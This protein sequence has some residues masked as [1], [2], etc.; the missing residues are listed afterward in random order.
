MYL[1]LQVEVK[2]GILIIGWY[3]RY[4]WDVYLHVCNEIQEATEPHTG[5]PGDE[6]VAMA[7]YQALLEGV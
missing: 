1:I 3:A 6:W 5:Q 4:L 2:R 7:A